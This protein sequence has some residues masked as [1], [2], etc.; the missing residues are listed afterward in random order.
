M[1]LT[2]KIPMPGFRPGI[3]FVNDTTF[4]NDTLR[5]EGTDSFTVNNV[6]SNI[7]KREVTVEK[8][9]FET[10]YM[11]KYIERINPVMEDAQKAGIKVIGIA[12]PSD[13]IV[14]RDLQ[15]GIQGQYPF[16]T[17]DDLLLKTIMRS[18][19]GVVLFKDGKIVQ[20]WHVRKLPGFE[21]IKSKY[22]K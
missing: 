6:V 3:S 20:K 2:Y 14:I 13:P 9:T 21:E 4:V 11:E 10:A 18:N 16:Y 1:V 8:A 22:I 7:A 12:P 5:I 19:P 15:I 17:A